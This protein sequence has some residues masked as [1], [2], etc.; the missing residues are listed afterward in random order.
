MV[1]KSSKLIS[2]A[3]PLDPLRRFLREQR[4]ERWQRVNTGSCPFT[5]DAS[6]NKALV[7]PHFTH[8]GR[9]SLGF[10]FPATCLQGCWEGGPRRFSPSPVLPSQSSP[11][12][13]PGRDHNHAAVGE[14]WGAQG[15]ALTR[16]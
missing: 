12:G 13:G 6:E 16:G 5:C 15:W 3:R 4:G 7:G 11:R 9:L 8:D 14:G 10:C 1:R 2:S